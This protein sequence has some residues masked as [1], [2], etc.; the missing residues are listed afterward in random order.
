MGLIGI[1]HWLLFGI[2]LL[3]ACSPEM[4]ARFQVELYMGC[5][6]FGFLLTALPR[7]TNAPSLTKQELLVFL[8]CVVVNA[9]CLLGGFWVASEITFALFLLTFLRFAR[10]RFRKENLSFLPPS[11][12]WV[13]H[14]ILC[15]FIGNLIYLMDHSGAL[16]VWVVGV[17]KGLLQQ[18]FILSVVCGIGGFLGPRLMGFFEPFMEK[19]PSCL[20]EVL[21]H[22]KKKILIHLVSAGLCF[23]SFWL[24]GLGFQIIGVLLRALVVTVQFFWTGAIA[25]WPRA[26]GLMPK[27]IFV[28]FWMI[29]VGYWGMFFWPAYRTAFLHVV[30]LGGFSLMTFA[31][32]TMVVLN[33]ADQSTRLAKPL[34][35]LRVSFTGLLVTLFFRLLAVGRPEHYFGLLAVA[36]LAW[37]IVAGAWI[38]FSFKFL[39]QGDPSPHC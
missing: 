13:P 38:V 6:I 36:A 10:L 20:E 27:M 34:W 16:P 33:H 5:F 18:G 19:G 4:H 31:V 24:E 37:I 12:I 8:L 1:G 30:F 7:F 15:A 2:G 11:F 17:G 35:V 25:Q 22:K 32:A 26:K 3:P 29:L 9:I 21:R 23:A 14:G 39:P 28:S